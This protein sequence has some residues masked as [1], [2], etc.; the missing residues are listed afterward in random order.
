MDI[1][2][3]RCNYLKATVWIIR[4]NSVLKWMGSKMMILFPDSQWVL[5][6]EEGLLETK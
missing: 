4:S 3:L 6:G 5:A 2:F 1:V